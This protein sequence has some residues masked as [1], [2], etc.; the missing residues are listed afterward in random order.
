VKNSI[1]RP[2]LY[3]F[4]KL[5]VKV[6]SISDFIRISRTAKLEPVKTF[7]SRRECQLVNHS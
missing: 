4:I 5:L 1:S 3:P 2:R 6:S 7:I